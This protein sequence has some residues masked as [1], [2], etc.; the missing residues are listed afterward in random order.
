MKSIVGEVVTFAN[1]KKTILHQFNCESQV[2]WVLIG[3][4][5]V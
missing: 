3:I 2:G 4:E 5:E 1:K